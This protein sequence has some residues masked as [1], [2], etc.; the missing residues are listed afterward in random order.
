ML[1]MPVGGEGGREGGCGVGRLFFFKEG[2]GEEGRERSWRGV[3][4]SC[5]REGGR[6]GGSAHGRAY[7]TRAG[8]GA[9]GGGGE[10]AVVRA[11]VKK[12]GGREGGREREGTGGVR[13]WRQERGEATGGG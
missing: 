5:V 9:G 6:E 13:E 4:H 1:F 2:G 8:G 12:E 3:R 10:S 7:G 11:S